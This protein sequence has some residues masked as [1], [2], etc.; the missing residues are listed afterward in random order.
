[1]SETNLETA[2]LAAGCFWCVEAVF[3]DLKGVEDVV[4]GYSGGYVE[5]PTYRQVCDGN[6][7]HARLR[8]IFHISPQCFWS[9]ASATT[10]SIRPR[11]LYGRDSGSAQRCMSFEDRNNTE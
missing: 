4:S 2:T 7:G 10:G 6:T 1:M 9:L 8:H 11:S 5:N 3:D